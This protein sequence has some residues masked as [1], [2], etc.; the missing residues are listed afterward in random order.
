MKTQ[1]MPPLLQPPQLGTE[2]LRMPALGMANH[3]PPSSSQDPS[4]AHNR[5][6]HLTKTLARKSYDSVVRVHST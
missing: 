4:P 2:V 6:P 3:L 1:V 5:H